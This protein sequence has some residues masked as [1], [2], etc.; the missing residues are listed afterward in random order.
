M[1]KIVILIIA[2]MS[3]SSLANAQITIKGKQNTE[4]LLSIRMGFIRLNY[5]GSYYL[6]MSTTNQFD[7]AMILPLGKNKQ[8][9][10]T[11]TQ[12]LIDISTTIKKGDCIEVESIYG[13]TFRIY[14]FA[15]NTITIQSD[16][17]AAMSNTNKAELTRILD[18]ITYDVR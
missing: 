18:T 12:S 10:M 15:K 17:Y 5:D 6:A 13:Q 7:D 2:L 16:G 9:A 1:K 11:T 14:I 4:T 8:E 3:L